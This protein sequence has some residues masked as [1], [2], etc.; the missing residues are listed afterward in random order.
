M[1]YSR[2]QETTGGFLKWG[3]PWGTMHFGDPPFLTLVRGPR[4]L[5]KTH[6]DLRG[7]FLGDKVQGPVLTAH[8]DE[9]HETMDL[10]I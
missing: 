4:R 2:N 8:G 10:T 3:V 5:K 1:K 9:R 7:E 6:P